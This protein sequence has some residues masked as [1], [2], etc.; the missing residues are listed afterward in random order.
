MEQ[1]NAFKQFE[2]NNWFKRNLSAK[3]NYVAG[4][5]IV[6]SLL[7]DYKI[8]PDRFL[9]I[10]CSSGYRVNGV[11]E[12]Y[13]KVEAHGIDASQEAVTFGQKKYP[14]V[15]LLNGTA[16]DLSIYPTGHFDVVVVGFVFYVVDRGLMLKVIAEIDRVLK[17]K[18]YIVIL[19]FSSDR[20]TRNKYQHITEFEAYSYK[21]NYESIFLG[22]GMYQLLD[23]STRQYESTADL[24][25]GSDYS[26]N[27]S[28]TL[29]KKDV[30]ASY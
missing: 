30:Y 9:E 13:P 21:Q 4:N 16:D 19:D 12:L 14:A 3:K 28:L 18:G 8:N 10:G 29:L 22:T 1:R 23:K 11:K 15:N 6:L 7:K 25:A 5:D 17:D 24:Y 2:G 20:M 26:N 27:L